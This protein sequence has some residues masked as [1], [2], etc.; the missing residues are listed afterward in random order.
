MARN[1]LRIFRREVLKITAQT[2]AENLGISEK[3][4][5]NIESGV[6]NPSYAVMAKFAHYVESWSARSGRRVDVWKVFENDSREI[7]V[8]RYPIFLEYVDVATD[9]KKDNARA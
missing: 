2:M 9:W 5:Q 1:N 4:Y 3:H 6:F 8:K 7:P